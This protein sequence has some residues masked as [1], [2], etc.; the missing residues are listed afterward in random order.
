MERTILFRGIIKYPDDIFKGFWYGNLI[1]Y[2]NGDTFIRQIETGKEFEV[3]TETVGQFTG[4]TDN[5]GVKIFEGDLWIG[6]GLIMI[7]GIGENWDTIPEKDR[8]VYVV[9]FQ[10]SLPCGFVAKLLSMYNNEDFIQGGFNRG[11]INN[12]CMDSYS[13]SNQAH[14]GIII[15]NIHDKHVL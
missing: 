6:S 8:K 2:A 10:K 7:A 3:I 13:F 11:D 4:L 1:I 12:N 9:H 15:G 14:T 5:N